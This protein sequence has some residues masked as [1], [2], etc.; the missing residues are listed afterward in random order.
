[1]GMELQLT[2]NIILIKTSQHKNK[3]QR[4]NDDNVS[5]NSSKARAM[6]TIVK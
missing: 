4:I 1:M 2:T 5:N 3:Y 6:S